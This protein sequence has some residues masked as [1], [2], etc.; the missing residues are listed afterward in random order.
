MCTS[1]FVSLYITFFAYLHKSVFACVFHLCTCDKFGLLQIDHI[2][3]LMAQQGDKIPLQ[4]K[5]RNGEIYQSTLDM[6]MP[7]EVSL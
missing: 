1:A 6:M 7:D 2:G 3:H 5:R 4:F